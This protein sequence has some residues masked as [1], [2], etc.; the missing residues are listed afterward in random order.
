MLLYVGGYII[1]RKRILVV[2]KNKALAAKVVAALEEAGYR[3]VMASDVLEGLKKL[4][5]RYPDLIVVSRES[6]IVNEEDPYLQIRQASYM[7]IIVLGSKEEV[8][9]TLELGADAYMTKPP[10]LDELVARV[11]SLLRRKQKSNLPGGS[12]EPEIKNYLN[13]EGDNSNGLTPTEFRLASCL[14][15]NEGR[16]LDYRHLISEVW[17]GR[18]VSRDTLHFHMRSLKTKLADVGIFQMRGI[19]YCLSGS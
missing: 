17:G 1:K 16:L 18:E 8:A 13:K 6:P 10:D 7:P 19:G 3:V 11:N 12:P 15:L 5:E 9:E 2:E 14:A 4:Y